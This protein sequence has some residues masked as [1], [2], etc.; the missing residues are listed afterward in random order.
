MRRS[1]LFCGLVMGA[2]GAGWA[3]PVARASLIVP[4]YSSST[5]SSKIYLDFDGDTTADWGT[6]HPGTTPA[7]STDADTDN[8]SQ[9]ELD[10]I[11]K[12]WQGVSEKYSPFRIN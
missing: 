9:E 7:Y 4:A 12:I 1:R 5:F 8:F 6:Y 3:A 11:Y 2:I 10:N